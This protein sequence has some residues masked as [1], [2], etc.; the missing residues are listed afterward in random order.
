M[1]PV[2]VYTAAVIGSAVLA[3]RLEYTPAMPE[4]ITGGVTTMGLHIHLFPNEPW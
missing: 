4:A 2:M 1:S 3:A